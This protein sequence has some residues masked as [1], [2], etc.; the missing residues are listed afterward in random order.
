MT[1]VAA[2]PARLLAV[3]E[4]RVR[5]AHAARLGWL[6]LL[7]F[8]V[9]FGAARW[10]PGT[11]A[12]AR[13]AAADRIVFGACAA[14]AVLVAAVPAATA[15]PLDVRGGAARALLAAPVSRLAVVAGGVLGHGVYAALVLVG[16]VGAAVL[17]QE[18]GG[19]GTR[20]REAPRGFVVV[21]PA[22]AAAVTRAEP[23]LDIA[24]EL[25]AGALATGQLDVRLRPQAV[26]EGG[27]LERTSEFRVT[28]QQP[29]RP[30]EADVVVPFTPGR[31]V[32]A[33]LPAGGLDHRL[34]TTLTVHRPE[35]AWGL[36][37]DAAS[38]EVAGAPRLHL[39]NCLTAA[40]CLVPL[41]FLVAAGAGA[42]STRF[43]TPTAVGV[44]LA[45]LVLFTG[46]DVLRDASEYVLRRDARSQAAHAAAHEHG[47][48]DAQEDAHE[49][50]HDH[51]ADVSLLQVGLARGALAVLA[52]VPPLDVFDRG[53]E[54]G[55]GRVVARGALGRAAVAGA[56]GVA[57]FVLL[58]WGLLARREIV[59][60]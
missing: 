13:A 2:G 46:Q 6:V 7:A 18:V 40:A 48:E 20:A 49:D 19:L 37:F 25:P 57:L 45:A 9:G 4:L 34:P 14:L 54:I 53:A 60:R 24:F 55:A 52:A 29:R 42:A 51:G 31:P 30:P 27:E 32:R 3:A 10:T 59:P 56:P 39:A 33:R 22:A 50:D 17:G 16:C 26:N 1:R 12:A 5:Q 21:G 28:L 15:L 41:L 23:E 47:E 44:V 38:I 58:G 43:G 36:R 8:A 35:G 11:D